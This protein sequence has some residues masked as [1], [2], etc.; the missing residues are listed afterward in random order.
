MSLPAQNPSVAAHHTKSQ[1]R[2]HL[3]HAPSGHSKFIFFCS[4]FHLVLPD[5]Q[6]FLLFFEHWALPQAFAL[7]RASQEHFL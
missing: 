4:S 5:L 6:A 3:Y 7:A 2:N 1:I